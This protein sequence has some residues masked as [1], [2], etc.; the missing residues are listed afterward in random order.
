MKRIVEIEHNSVS[1]M[2]E[3]LKRASL[4][5][6]NKNVVRKVLV[7]QFK[8]LLPSL[9]LQLETIRQFV[10]ARRLVSD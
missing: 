10:E 9:H 4:S 7:D 6:G 3:K 8:I 5:L 2:I 1:K